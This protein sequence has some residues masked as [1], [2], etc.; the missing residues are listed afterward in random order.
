MCF[1]KRKPKEENLLFDAP[2]ADVMDYIRSL[3]KPDDKMVRT[4]MIEETGDVF[5]FDLFF[6]IQGMKKS[7]HDEYIFRLSE[8]NAQTKVDIKIIGDGAE[9]I[10]KDLIKKLNKRFP[11]KEEK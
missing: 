9:S 8:E 4:N 3:I 10:R 2:K 5:H 6:S 1:F 7:Y 11:K